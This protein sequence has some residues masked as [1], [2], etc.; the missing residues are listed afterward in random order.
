VI[1]RRCASV[2][3]G[4]LLVGAGLP[5]HAA[6]IRTTQAPDDLVQI[7]P[8]ITTIDDAPAIADEIVVRFTSDATNFARQEA[9][10]MP[11][12]C[13]TSDF[14]GSSF[15]ALGM[16]RDDRAAAEVESSRSPRPLS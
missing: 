16:L 7:T 8:E 13:A 1:W 15:D 2:L 14:P 11:P 4:I 3:V 12:E 10:G 9:R 5:V 6:Q